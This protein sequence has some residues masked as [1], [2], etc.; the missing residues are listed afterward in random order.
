MQ[1]MQEALT[2][3]QSFTSATAEVALFHKRWRLNKKLTLLQRK[4]SQ[5]KNYKISGKSQVYNQNYI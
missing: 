5:P 4:K 2:Y 3:E 1:A